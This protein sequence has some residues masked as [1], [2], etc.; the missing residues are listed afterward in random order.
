MG[1]G[2]E[3]GEDEMCSIA[4][5]FVRGNVAKDETVEAF[6]VSDAGADRGDGQE[7]SP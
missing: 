4:A 3:P 2:E 1:G 5:L 7:D 6:V